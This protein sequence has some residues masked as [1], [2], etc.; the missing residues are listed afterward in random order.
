MQ[1]LDWA[2]AVVETPVTATVPIANATMKDFS[3]FVSPLA[4]FAPGGLEPSDPRPP[5]DERDRAS[6]AVVVCNGM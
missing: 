5:A 4:W 6:E 3:M 2:S 1:G